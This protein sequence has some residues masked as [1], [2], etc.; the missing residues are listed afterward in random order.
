MHGY[1]VINLCMHVLQYI[2]IMLSIEIEPIG[3]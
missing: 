1:I 3:L 2:I